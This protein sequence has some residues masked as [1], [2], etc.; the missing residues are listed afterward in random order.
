MT[1]MQ[2]TVAM[3][4]EAVVIGT[5]AGG[6]SA[7]LRVPGGLPE[8][9][10]LPVM[11]VLHLPESR[12]SHVAGTFQQRLALPVREAADKESIAASTVYFAGPGHHMSL[13]ND[14]SFS[15]SCKA[16]VHYSRPSIDLLMESASDTCGAAL[17]GILLTGAD[18]A[19]GMARIRQRGGLTVVQ[20]PAEAQ[21][22]TMPEAAIRKLKPSLI[23]TLDGISHL[24]LE[25]EKSH[26]EPGKLKHPSR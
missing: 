3:S 10:G 14:R 18:G 5:S 23:R 15:L 26:V 16:P 1:G 4:A 19:A 13:E 9:F 7:L 8:S 11:V 25:L 24:L 20:D 22:A 12:Y 2:A 21:V 6:V 17:A